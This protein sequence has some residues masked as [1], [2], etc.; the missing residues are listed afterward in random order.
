MN[1]Q[2]IAILGDL[3]FGKH[4]DSVHLLNYQEQFFNDIFFPTL[5]EHQINIIIQLG[6]LFDKRKHINFYTLKRC[7]EFF[8]DQIENHQMT[9]YS[10]LGN[11]DTFYKTTNELNSPEQLLR[12]YSSI[13]IV[14]EPCTIPIHSQLQ[15]DLIPWI[16]VSNIDR[17]IQFIQQSSST[18]CAGHFEIQG[19]ELFQGTVSTQ[20][21]STDMF[22]KYHEVYSGHFH[23]QS[24][25]KNIHYIGIPYQLTFMDIDDE[26]GFYII[27]TVQQDKHFIANPQKIYIKKVINSKEDAWALDVEDKYVQLILSSD[28]PRHDLKEIV[29]FLSGKNPINVSVQETV[30]IPSE[31]TEEL[32]Q[33][34]ITMN[35]P[36]EILINYIQHY[37]PQDMDRMIP[38]IQLVYNETINDNEE[39]M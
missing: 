32:T 15:F 30:D 9:M 18:H 26:K 24:Q 2:K 4:S 20:G 3:H 39:L 28:I 8:F 27:D 5:K 14:S 16:N 31:E 19:A 29:S 12:S 6:D 21:L 38:L 22:E 11:H 10:L 36:L 35:S 33:D 25:I 23:K 13:H 37:M 34:L 1:K 7:S 17:A